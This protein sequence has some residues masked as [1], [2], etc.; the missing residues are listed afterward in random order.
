MKIRS[1]HASRISPDRRSRRI[2]SRRPCL[3]SV[4]PVHVYAAKDDKHKDARVRSYHNATLGRSIEQFL[5]RTHD[6]MLRSKRSFELVR[7]STSRRDMRCRCHRT[8]ICDGWILSLGT[9]QVEGSHARSVYKWHVHVVLVVVSFVFVRNNISTSDFEKNS[10]K[11][12][13]S[14]LRASRG[15]TTAPIALVR[16]YIF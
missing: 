15:V 10:K 4:K 7:M 13:F 16:G 11:R 9:F 1:P 12:E 2:S 14:S 3:R 6:G 8:T 5:V